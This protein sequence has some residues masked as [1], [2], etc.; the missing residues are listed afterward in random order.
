MAGLLKRAGDKKPPGVLARVG[1]DY[2]FAAGI[3]LA[4]GFSMLWP[5]P[6]QWLY[7]HHAVRW[8]VVMVFVCSGL[9]LT[10]PSLA[11][12][13]RQV[14]VLIIGLIG[15]VVVFP[16]VA[17]GLSEM[18]GPGRGM[19]VGLMLIAASPPTVS[20][21]I[22]ITIL[23]GGTAALAVVL[24]VLG[25]VAAIVSMPLVLGWTLSAV[26]E[27]DRVSLLVRLCL[28][29]LLPMACGLLA[30]GRWPSLPVRLGGLLKV[31][32]GLCVL[33]VVLTAV[34][35]ARDDLLGSANYLWQ[36]VV[37][38]GAL[39]GVMLAINFG[40]GRLLRLTR[41]D[42]Q[43]L[44][45]VSSQKALTVSSLVWA[46]YF[47]NYPLAIIACIVFHLL[48]IVGDSLLAQVWARR[49]RRS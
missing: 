13:L 30:R 29:I 46:E 4:A 43:A 36:P 17:R 47:A 49:A 22:V 1:R 15:I 33:G 40:L 48:Q 6:G 26:V 34:G 35:R 21:G 28:I 3:V 41:P 8:L 44:V 14:R 38:M 27:V 12:S 9:N 7:H 11:R 20:S 39:H 10:W 42:H 31:L 37:L 16:L 32:P 24:T 18:F 2:L 25:N 5:A 45:F 19:L 23:A